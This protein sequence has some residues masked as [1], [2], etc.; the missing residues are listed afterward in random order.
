MRYRGRNGGRLFRLWLGLFLVLATPLLTSAAY[1]Q[2]RVALVIGNSKYVHETML[3]NPGND[4][5]E[6]AAIL[7]RMKFD[8]VQVVLDGDLATM[9]S[10]LAQ[11]ARRAD[12]ADLSLI[13]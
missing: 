1:A 10:A 9:Q 8:D 12:A 5:R 11:F 3:A 7:K 6:V 4:A 13:Y 2:K